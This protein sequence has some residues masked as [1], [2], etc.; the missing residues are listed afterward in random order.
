MSVGKKLT[1]EILSPE[2]PIYQGPATAVSSSNNKGKFD[3]LPGHSRFISIINDNL[4]VRT[5]AEM[6]EF[7]CKEGVLRCYD[8]RVQVYLAGIE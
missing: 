5:D 6:R 8:D 2:G 3:I 7:E 4:S 1:V